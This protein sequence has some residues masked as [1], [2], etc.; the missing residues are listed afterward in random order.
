MGIHSCI[1]S[2]SVV[3]YS[4]WLSWVVVKFASRTEH[5]SVGDVMRNRC[6][7]GIS[8]FLSDDR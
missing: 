8:Q 3:F 4:A 7:G 6:P 5:V 2:N 1:I